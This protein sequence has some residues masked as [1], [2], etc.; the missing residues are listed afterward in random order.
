MAENSQTKRN[1]FPT[2][3]KSI[4]ASQSSK[5]FKNTGIELKTSPE[6]VKIDLVPG[7]NINILIINEKNK[8]MVEIQDGD[9]KCC[10][11][12]KNDISATNSDKQQS[13]QGNL[14]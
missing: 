13:S 7:K 14:R 1:E 10:H 8:H 9:S 3:P 12:F 11:T 2:P 5:E 6:D 4:S